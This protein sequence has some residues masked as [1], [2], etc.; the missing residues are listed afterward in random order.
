LGNTCLSAP[1]PDPKTFLL[2]YTVPD[3][4]QIQF[5]FTGQVISYSP[6]VPELSTWAMLLIGFAGIGFAAYRNKDLPRGP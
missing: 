1:L 4:G 5:A 2:E 3:S 6:A